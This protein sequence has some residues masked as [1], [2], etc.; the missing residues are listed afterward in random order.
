MSRRGILPQRLKMAA[1][2]S[3]C[4]EPFAKYMREFSEALKPLARDSSAA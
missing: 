3:V 1:V 2:C 4:A